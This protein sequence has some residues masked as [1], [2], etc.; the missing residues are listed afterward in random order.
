MG[1]E[2]PDVSVSLN[3]G[4]VFDVVVTFKCAFDADEGRGALAVA[5]YTGSDAGV[6]AFGSGGELS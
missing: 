4:M 1:A 2:K 5:F 3:S 6:H